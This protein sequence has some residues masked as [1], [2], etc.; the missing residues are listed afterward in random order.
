MDTIRLGQHRVSRL[1][2]GSN[3]F[4][5]FSHQGSDRDL[6]MKRYYTTD[7]IKSTLRD[8]EALG[9]NTVIGRTDHHVMRVL[10]EYWDQ[11]GAIQWFAQT[12]P[13]VGSHEACVSR[14][15]AGGAKACH[16]HGGVMD[17]LFAQGGLGEIPPVVDMIHRKGMLAGIAGHNP[18]V[19]EW[20]EKNLDA[21]YYMCSYYNSAHRDQRA[22]H[23]PGAE[24]WFLEED[25]RIMT[26]LIATLSKPVIHYKVMAAGRNDPAEAFAYVARHLRQGDAVCVGVFT[27]GIPDML[28]NDIELLD[29]ALAS[30]TGRGEA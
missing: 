17:H 26:E 2:L 5:G 27:Q 19:I 12:C 6:A 28:K 14:A 13:E 7:T 10:L 11:G 20:A 16:I 15:A 22:E 29:S 3:P 9:I 18:K 24:E 25:R 1:I 4:S 8:A 21:D 30:R 23:V